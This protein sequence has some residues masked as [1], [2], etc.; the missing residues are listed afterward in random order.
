MLRTRNII[1]ILV[2]N[3]LIIMLVSVFVEAGAVQAKAREANALIRIAA[4]MALQNVLAT[5]DFF[6]EG[7]NQPMRMSTDTGGTQFAPVNPFTHVFPGTME[8]VHQTMFG[9]GNTRFQNVAAQSSAIR[10]PMFYQGWHSIPSL[11][12]M[13]L[14]T[15]SGS[16][17]AAL[18]FGTMVPEMVAGYRYDT[19]HHTSDI[20]GSYFF[21]PLALGVTYIDQD[22][23]DF[24]FANNM[25]LLMRARYNHVDDG[26]DARGRQ[27]IHRGSGF[28]SSP[29]YALH[30]QTAAPM[31]NHLNRVVNNG[32]WSYLRGEFGDG[33]GLNGRGFDNGHPAQIRYKLVDL[34]NANNDAILRLVF[35][36]NT[37]RAGLIGV[38]TTFS[39]PQ[40]AAVGVGASSFP[41]IIAEVTF[42]AELFIPLD[43]MVIRGWRLTDPGIGVGGMNNNTL[44]LQQV[45]AAG[46]AV[47]GPNGGIMYNYTTY[48]AVLP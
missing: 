9:P 27:G 24:Y 23:L 34:N 14:P 3:Y 48:F 38:S 45:N 20:I 1:L 44:N 17:Q 29:F 19:T 33:H 8:Q 7:S 41:M 11:A 4:D 22:M 40:Y 46:G 31:I 13:G 42:T 6:V 47:N 21:S 10:T 35:G 39:H 37:T 25:D 26:F 36:G 28:A 43:T 30:N 16:N 18:I 15:F 32:S 5:D 12:Q 2:F